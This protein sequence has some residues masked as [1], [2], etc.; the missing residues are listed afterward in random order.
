MM[1]KIIS[2]ALCLLIMLCAV[3]FGVSA[4]T[5]ETEILGPGVENMCQFEYLKRD[6][7]TGDGY[8]ILEF[9][10]NKITLSGDNQTTYIPKGSDVKI[11]IK[12]DTGS[13]VSAVVYD[14]GPMGFDGPAQEL[15]MTISNYKSDHQL[16]ITYTKQSF[17]C[18]VASV[19]NGTVK[20]MEP[21]TSG[22]SVQVPMGANFAFTAEAQ[23]GF[24]ILSVS[25]NGEEIDLTQFGQTGANKLKRFSLELPQIFEDTDVLVVFSSN[26][27]SGIYGDVNSDKKVNVLDATLI[28]KSVAGLASFDS[29]QKMWGDVD[30]DGKI[31]VKDA[32]TVQKYSAGIVTEFPAQKNK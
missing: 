30:A 3:P 28:Q 23:T 27:A 4:Q 2:L 25:I 10:G 15:Q 17:E 16:K 7:S 6:V 21:V 14:G 9:A 22:T 32:T 26:A 12:A 18:S 13:A 19:G 8:V 5:D 24:E 20:V 31:T 11:T 29:T 1:N